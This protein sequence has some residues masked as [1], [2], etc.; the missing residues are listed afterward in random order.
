MIHHRLQILIWVILLVRRKCDGFAVENLNISPLL[1]KTPPAPLVTNIV[2]STTPV[3]IHGNQYLRPVALD[4]NETPRPTR[5]MVAHSRT[6]TPVSPPEQLGPETLGANPEDNSRPLPRDLEP[7]A[8]MS[9]HRQSQDQNEIERGA[10]AKAKRKAKPKPKP[11]A[12]AKAKGKAREPSEGTNDWV[13]SALSRATNLY[14][15]NA[16]LGKLGAN[17]GQPSAMYPYAE[18]PLALEHSNLEAS[19]QAAQRE[20]RMAEL[21]SIE[22]SG[23]QSS[24]LPAMIIGQEL[25][26]ERGSQEPHVFAKGNDEYSEPHLSIPL[27]PSLPLSPQSDAEM[28]QTSSVRDLPTSALGKPQPI[29][30]PLQLTVSCQPSPL[31]SNH[32]MDVDLEMRPSSH[33]QHPSPSHLTRESSSYRHQ[34]EPVVNRRHHSPSESHVRPPPRGGLHQH[35]SPV[36]CEKQSGREDRHEEIG[37]ENDEQNSDE[38]QYANNNEDGYDEEDWD[39]MYDGGRGDQYDEDDIGDP[40]DL[41]QEPQDGP[42]FVRLSIPKLSSITL[43]FER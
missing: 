38:E 43:K 22:D 40:D 41:N 39:K 11:K 35:H 5:P 19:S 29:L 15:L 23:S 34:G 20:E 27:P 4:I 25:P 36:T 33:H 37:Y 31:L 42:K 7:E 24:P 8:P 32:S 21:E 6:D 26:F 18:T 17:S 30:S 14:H 1:D 16:I 2:D 28:N 13:H 3:F 12:K 10:G 9:P